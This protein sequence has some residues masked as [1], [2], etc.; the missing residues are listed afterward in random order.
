MGRW[1]AGEEQSK[2]GEEKGRAEA[3][4]IRSTR[5]VSSLVL[6]DGYRPSMCP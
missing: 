2:A 5:L 1:G 4:E 3:Q 6:L